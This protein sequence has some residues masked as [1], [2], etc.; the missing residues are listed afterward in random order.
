MRSTKL[1]D[2]YQYIVFHSVTHDNTIKALNLFIKDNMLITYHHKP[3][4][5]LSDVEQLI[6]EHFQ[7]D[8]DTIGF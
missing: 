8:L 6:T 1:M 3:F 2:T 5:I 4:A 7:P